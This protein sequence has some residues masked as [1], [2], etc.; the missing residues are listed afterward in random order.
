MDEH[1]QACAAA[2][3]VGKFPGHIRGPDK[4]MPVAQAAA[5]GMDCGTESNSDQATNSQLYVPVSPDDY[6]QQGVS[7]APMLVMQGQRQ[8]QAGSSYQQVAI[9]TDQG[10]NL[11]SRT[12][13]AAGP[14]LSRLR[15]HTCSRGVQTSSLDYPLLPPNFL[16]GEP[17]NSLSMEFANLGGYDFHMPPSA[18]PLPSGSRSSESSIKERIGEAQN[19]KRAGDA[20]RNSVGAWDVCSLGK[21]VE[22]SLMFMEACEWMQQTIKPGGERTR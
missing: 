14:G 16:E 4:L 18:L 22:A 3:K 9:A 2:G 13:A 11:L 8:T 10:P 17:S 20:L 12:A 6:T 7:L 1:S 21:Y 5:A 15:T 19:T